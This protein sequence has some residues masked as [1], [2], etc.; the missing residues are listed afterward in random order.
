[1]LSISHHLQSQWTFDILR[2][3]SEKINVTELVFKDFSDFELLGWNFI[4]GNRPRRGF[5]G[6]SRFR[7]SSIGIVDDRL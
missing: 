2:F 6:F 5:C 4:R 3:Y 1:M 7:Q